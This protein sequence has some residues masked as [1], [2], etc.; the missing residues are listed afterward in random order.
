MKKDPFCCF[1]TPRRG[2]ITPL[3]DV[4]CVWLKPQDDSCCGKDSR[5]FDHEKQNE[6]M[7]K[8]NGFPDDSGDDNF[9]R[10]AGWGV[11]KG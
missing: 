6:N 5:R 3:R 11:S 10:I 2:G 9:V 8:V 7:E 4:I 1:A